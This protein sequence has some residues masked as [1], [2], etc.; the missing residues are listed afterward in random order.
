MNSKKIFTVRISA[1]ILLMISF[2][3]STILLSSDLNELV[4]SGG[5]FGVKGEIEVVLKWGDPVLRRDS[6]SEIYKD[7]PEKVASILQEFYS[8]FQQSGAKSQELRSLICRILMK[9]NAPEGFGLEEIVLKVNG[10]IWQK[11][12]FTSEEFWFMRLFEEGR[13]GRV[14]SNYYHV[15]EGW[16]LV[17]STCKIISY[18]HPKHHSYIAP[19]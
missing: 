13:E 10:T 5:I 8:S 9:L 6:I 16:R 11:I 17:D 2:G 12:K 18:S 14:N 19:K 15:K 1:I 3:F 4:H 7:K